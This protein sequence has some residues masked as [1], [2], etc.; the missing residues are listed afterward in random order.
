MIS[1]RTALEVYLDLLQVRPRSNRHE[2]KFEGLQI[3]TGKYSNTD[4]DSLQARPGQPVGFDA[5][6]F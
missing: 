3:Y 6:G 5:A 2:S 1:A 4:T